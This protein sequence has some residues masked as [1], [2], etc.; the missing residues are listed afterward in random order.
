MEAYL[1]TGEAAKK[2][3]IEEWDQMAVFVG[4][5]VYQRVVGPSTESLKHYQPFSD[6]VYG[7][8]L[9]R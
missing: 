5:Q 6:N 7:E 1:S 4:E 3:K 8:L 9:P 2:I